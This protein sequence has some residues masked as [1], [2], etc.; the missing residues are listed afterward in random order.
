MFPLTFTAANAI[1]LQDPFDFLHRF[2]DPVEMLDILNVYLVIVN[3]A[4]VVG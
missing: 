4:A 1:D 3:A 2:D